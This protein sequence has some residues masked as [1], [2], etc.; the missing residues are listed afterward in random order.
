MSPHRASV[1]IRS[2]P[3]STPARLPFFDSDRAIV[4]AL[5]AGQPAGGAALYDR[6]H[7]H[8]RRILVRVLGHAGDL[9]DLVHDVFVSAIDGIE[10]LDEPDALRG[11]LTSIAVFHARAEIRARTRRRLFPLFSHDDLPERE[12]HV[13][14]PE[15]DEAVRRTYD[16]LAKLAPDERIAFALRVVDG[17]ELVE[18]ADACGVSLATIKRRLARAHNKFRNIARRYPELSE[19]LTR[20][21][22]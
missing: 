7:A 4:A 6:Y 5:C 2:S 21:T 9:H 17:M 1:P 18:V 22:P 13:V 10:R 19:W 3:P 16:V 8:V 11:W 15:L 20:G 14:T 12:A